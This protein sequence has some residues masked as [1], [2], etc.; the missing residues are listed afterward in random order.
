MA[1]STKEAM[2]AHQKESKNN[3][4]KANGDSKS[5]VYTKQSIKT[6]QKYRSE[7]SPF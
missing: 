2:E 5:A 4:W 7:V 6:N 1:L 3:M